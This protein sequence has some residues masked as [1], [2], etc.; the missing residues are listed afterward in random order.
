MM[1]KNKIKDILR[2]S[3]V[4]PHQDSVQHAKSASDATSE[5]KSDK[6]HKLLQNDIINHAAVVRNMTGEEWT[7]N[8]EATN[9]SKFRKKLNKMTN[10]E[11]GTYS[12]D[13]DELGQIE[14]ILMGLSS[15]IT[16]TIGR[17]GK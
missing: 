3:G 8:S 1:D 12:F 13:D 14:K 11:G 2:E 10:D 17:Q 9:R 5:N 16:H 4:K 7:G 15:T 6:I